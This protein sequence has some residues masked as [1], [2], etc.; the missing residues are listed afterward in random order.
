MTD[1]SRVPEP[2]SSASASPEAA[3][4]RLFAGPA[5]KLDA[6]VD[7]L[8]RLARTGL[9]PREFQNA[10]L[11]QVCGAF[12]A[13]AAAVWTLDDAGNLH[14][15][16]EFR[17]E[18]IPWK[19]DVAA[20]QAHDAA[21]FGAL[22]ENAPLGLD[23]P[24]PAQDDASPT[25]YL[26]LFPWSVDAAE[27]GLVELVAVGALGADSRRALLEIGSA[28]AELVAE[29]R[30]RS[31]LRELRKRETLWRDWE[32]L[33]LCLHA[34][35]KPDEVCQAIAQE[36]R[37]FIGCDRASV[38]LVGRRR[39]RLGGASG[40]D[41]PNPHSEQTQALERLAAA[42]AAWGQSVVFEGDAGQLPPQV[43]QPL[44]TLV[45]LSHARAVAVVPLSRVPSAESTSEE[46]PGG[47]ASPSEPL[48]AM[49]LEHYSSSIF[50]DAALRRIAAVGRQAEA[51]LT[52][53][54]SVE[55]R[56]LAGISRGLAGL[57]WLTEARQLP[58]T[59]WILGTIASVSAAL[60]FVPAE[61]KIE[62]RGEMQPSLRR[63]IF[64][65]ADGIVLSVGVVE[66]EQVAAGQRLLTLTSPVLE[67][68]RSKLAGEIATAEKRLTAVRTLRLTLEADRQESRDRALQLTAEEEEVKQSLVNLQEQLDAV[69]RQ[70][71]ELEVASPL[72]GQI[73]TWEPRRLLDARPVQRGQRLLT[74]ADTAGPWVLELQ[75]PDDQIGHVRAA[76][77]AAKEPGT[78]ATIEFVAA[79]APGAFHT[80]KIREIGLRS[81]TSP[82]GESNVR[83][84]ADFDRGQVGELHPGA[85]VVAQIQC[86]RRALG[87]VWFHRL[88]EALQRFLWL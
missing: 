33:S 57:G 46:R 77:A 40:V 49:V 82:Q 32:E 68:E 73:T 67:A 36:G 64:A 15:S 66:G 50:D 2:L 79:G 71:A 37:R 69:R 54:I 5:E 75:V 76:Q 3:R 28:L 24:L 58:R 72:P 41:V 47:D 25:I 18:G 80:A 26:G 8:Q 35:L 87:Y 38:V 34:S 13:A 21:L 74:V 65:P 45:E 61:L 1:S 83:V 53:A 52:N 42:V 88:F 9:G 78:D 81:E 10:V 22:R 7:E 4:V 17:W 48:G 14:L 29:H 62:A 60:I 27:R 30:E 11:A 23:F 19:G 59:V 85:T 63:E 51:A 43:A 6:L 84:T 39:P 86:G 56:P 44:E 31:A 55:D 20:G 16:G 70:L 12:G